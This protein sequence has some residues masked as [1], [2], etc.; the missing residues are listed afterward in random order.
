MKKLTKYFVQGL[1]IVVPVIVSIAVIF[2]FFGKLDFL[3]RKLF[4]ITTPFV[5]LLVA[6]VLITLVGFLANNYAGRKVFGLIEKLFK[7]LPLVKMLYNS[8]KDITSAF[9]GEKKGFDKP[10]IVELFPAGP[11]VVGFVTRQ[12]LEELSLANHVAVYLPQ[13]YNFAGSLI[14]VPASSVRPLDIDSSQAMSFIVS[15]GLCGK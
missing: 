1:L 12:S 7:R 4:G 10:V 2:W 14:L 6:L 5:S 13:S 15:G 8:V 3:L 9:A 11:K